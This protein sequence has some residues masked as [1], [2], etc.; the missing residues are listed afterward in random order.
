MLEDALGS[1]FPTVRAS[2]FPGI[3]GDTR[4]FSQSFHIAELRDGDQGLA[5]PPKTQVMLTLVR[6]SRPHCE[7][8]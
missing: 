3:L 4:M 1:D 6:G 7:T 8:T 5:F 2:D